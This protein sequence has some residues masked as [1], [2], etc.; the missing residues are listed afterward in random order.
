MSLVH[1]SAQKARLSSWAPRADL[2]SA[3]PA[4]FIHL[5]TAFKTDPWFG[6]ADNG[7][8][9]L[10]ARSAASCKHNQSLS[11]LRKSRRRTTRSTAE[12][13]STAQP[14]ATGCAARILASRQWLAQR[15]L[16]T[17]KKCRGEGEII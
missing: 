1:L 13:S 7:A 2:L 5:P 17:S 4:N 3:A 12:M 16:I 9:K 8:G 11:G 6:F 10:Q 15:S 14:D